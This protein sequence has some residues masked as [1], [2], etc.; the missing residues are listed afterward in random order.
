MS[1]IGCAVL[2]AGGSR[3]LGL[4]KQLVL[5]CGE[6]LARRAVR[7]ARGCACEE[8]AVVVGCHRA[9]VERAITGL[10]VDTLCADDWASGLGASVGLATRWARARGLSALILA[11]CDQ[12]LLS[13]EHIDALAQKHRT[14]GAEI[15]A[16]S[17]AGTRGVPALF[18]ASWFDRLEALSGDRGAGAL[19]RSTE[20]VDE[21]LW[22]DGAFDIDE[23]ADVERM[24]AL[25]RRLEAARERD[26][27]SGAFS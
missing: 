15:V 24:R 6:T 18:G 17:Y 5:F 22:E 21:V 11:V 27:I 7:A 4:P 13:A 3:R 26:P 9:E 25:E 12:P 10:G 23:V 2:A 20:R 1:R 8:V 14:G 16:S 19:L